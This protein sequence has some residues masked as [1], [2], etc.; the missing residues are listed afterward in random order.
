[1]V[2]LP[3]DEGADWA[4]AELLDE[5]EGSEIPLMLFL[6]RLERV[7]VR[8]EDDSTVEERALTRIRKRR[9]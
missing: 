6:K 8:R 3:L 4:V 9:R 7:T 5:L 1:M 2:R